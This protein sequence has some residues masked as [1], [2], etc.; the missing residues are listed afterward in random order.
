MYEPITASKFLTWGWKDRQKNLT[1]AFNFKTSGRKKRCYHHSGGILFILPPV[2]KNY[3][4][5]DDYPSYCKQIDAINQILSSL[6][7]TIKSKVTVRLYSDQIT[8]SFDQLK[9][10]QNINPTIKIDLGR[11]NINTLINRNSLVVHCYD[12]TGILETLS[13]NIPT[14]GFWLP[15]DTL[16][17]YNSRD[18]MPVVDMITASS[19]ALLAIILTADSRV[20]S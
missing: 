18:V 15:S 12:S 6:P 7:V 8:M 20:I 14:I 1:I 13:L 9:A 11:A 5:S 19:V 17:S 16:Y 2:P 4:P 3:G 10:I